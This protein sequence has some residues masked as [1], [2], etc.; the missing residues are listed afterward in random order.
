MMKTVLKQGTGQGELW[1]GSH[2]EPALSCPAG[3]PELPATKCW[4]KTFRR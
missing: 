1:G 2:E 4:G 3:A